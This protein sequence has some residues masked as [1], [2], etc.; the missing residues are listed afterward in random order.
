[1]VRIE[2]SDKVEVEWDEENIY[3]YG[4]VVSIKPGT[5]VKVWIERT[6]DESDMEKL[7]KNDWK[8]IV[9]EDKIRVL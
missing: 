2:E 3:G 4:K 1:M 7:E 9:P 8:I 6:N 5:G